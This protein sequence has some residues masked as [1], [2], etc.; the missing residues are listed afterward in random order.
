MDEGT[1]ESG[2]VG[3]D[4]HDLCPDAECCEC[5]GRTS[6]L[7]ATTFGT[8]LGVF[9]ASVCATC[10][11]A[12]RSPRWGVTRVVERVLDHCTHLGITVDQMAVLR[13]EWA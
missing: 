11:V 9:C 4:R 3:L 13:A 6:M 2:C 12:G 7:R 8:S 1:Q 10:L 5:C